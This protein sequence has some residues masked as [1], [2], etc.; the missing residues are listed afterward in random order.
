MISSLYT[1]AA[2]M[3][4]GERR[5]DVIANNIANVD[6]PGY[7]ADG[8]TF[9]DYLLTHGYVKGY[10]QDPPSPIPQSA[11]APEEPSSPD[12][13]DA[14]NP[15][16]FPDEHYVNFSEGPLQETGNTFDVAIRGRGFFMVQ[17]DKGYAFT[18]KGIFHV[19]PATKYLV[20]DDGYPVMKRVP[21]GQPPEPITIDDTTKEV[22]I[23]YDGGVVV[24]G[25][26]VGEIDVRD[27]KEP[28]NQ[29]LEKAG[30]TLFVPKDPANLG[31]SRDPDE[32]QVLQGYVEKSNV[33]AVRSMVELINAFRHY[34]SCQKAIQ[35]TFEDVTRA[36]VTEVG[37]V[38]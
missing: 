26:L 14:K 30:Y 21:E 10:P 16:V 15:I 17:T 31:Y 3:V 6:T 12:P 33:N 5:I 1:G 27:F 25:T 34:E 13:F 35:I 37:R 20:T 18:R 8:M 24:D 28:Y 22:V 23:R 9:S 32:N 7:K 4:V 36:T 38:G 2:G 29:V 19:D 11:L